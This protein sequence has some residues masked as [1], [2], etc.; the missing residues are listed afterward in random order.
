MSSLVKISR[1]S[2]FSPPAHLYPNYLTS[3][4]LGCET[5]ENVANITLISLNCAFTWL[6]KLLCGKYEI[7]FSVEIPLN[8]SWKTTLFVIYLKRAI[9]INKSLWC[10]VE[11]LVITNSTN[12][13]RLL[14]LKICG[15]KIVILNFNNYNTLK[16]FRNNMESLFNDYS[17]IDLRKKLNFHH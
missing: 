8:L 10:I 17:F 3:S 11:R 16:K 7:C 5:S 14:K 13:W 1:K 15:K 4:F 9:N 2:T 12:F 6:N